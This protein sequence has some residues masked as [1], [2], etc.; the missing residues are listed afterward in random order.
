MSRGV[1]QGELARMLGYEQAYVSALEIGRKGPPSTEFVGKL[2]KV[3]DLSSIE[4]EA[5]HLAV[6]SSE[7]RLVIS[8]DADREVYKTLTELKKYL[9]KMR[10][11]QLRIIRDV[12]KLS[13]ELLETQ[14]KEMPRKIKRRLKTETTM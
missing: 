9:E 4:Q 7:R 1:R 5:L 10:P 13:E 3:Y 14:Q 11:E 12:A 2:I 6:A 8:H